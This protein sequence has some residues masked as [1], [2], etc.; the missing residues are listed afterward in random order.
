MFLKPRRVRRGPTNCGNQYFIDPPPEL[1]RIPPPFPHPDDLTGDLATIYVGPSRIG[2]EA[3]INLLSRH[4][5]FFANAFCHPFREASSHTIDLPD[6]VAA[7]FACVVR[8]MFEGQTGLDATS[9]GLQICQ[10]W[11][12]ADKLMMTALCNATMTVFP[13]RFRAVGGA[14]SPSTINYVFENTVPERTHPLRRI[15]VDV[16]A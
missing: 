15:I 6:D 16:F 1:L 8:W 12:L 14:I 13:A 7:A 5:P 2:F 10:V 4:S 11:I 3:P 9:T